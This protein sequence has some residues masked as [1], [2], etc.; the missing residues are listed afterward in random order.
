MKRSDRLIQ[1]VICLLCGNILL[2]SSVY[3]T[4]PLVKTEYE[5]RVD[6]AATDVIVKE[7]DALLT[8][9]RDF[10][11]SRYLVQ[12]V[13]RRSLREYVSKLKEIAE[14]TSKRE[15]QEKVS[16]DALYA[17]SLLQDSREYL[18]ENARG[19]LTNKWLAYY[20]IWIL[21]AEPDEEV[22]NE[23]RKIKLE[24][25]DN[26]IQGA[27]STAEYVF[28]LA[29][30]Y[31]T[32]SALDR[33]LDTL[34]KELGS[35]YNPFGG[36]EN[37][38]TENLNPEAEWAKGEILQ[39]SKQHPAEV[40]NKLDSVEQIEGRTAKHLMGLRRYFLRFVTDETRS[41]CEKLEKA[42]SAT[43]TEEKKTDR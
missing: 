4:I 19:H 16:F 38:P 3:A 13:G 33:K 26:H 21:A 37:E 9:E 22:L 41:V 27:V 17:I 39:L 40:A 36:D 25:K 43:A 15:N 8:G 42:R 31:A 32:T 28:S 35:G 18:I 6:S 30:K 5:K 29:Q 24:S 12:T 20:S 7:L 34:L 10:K 1:T 14:V 11:Q 2:I 23:L